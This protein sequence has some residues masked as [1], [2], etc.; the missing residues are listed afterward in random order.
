MGKKPKVSVVIPTHN[1]AQFLKAAIASVLNQTYQDFEIVVV[2]DASSDNTNEIVEGFGDKRVTYIRHEIN[3]G[4]AGSRNSGIANSSGDYLAFL[5]DDDEWL[6]EKLQMQVELMRN[7]SIKVGGVCTGSLSVE[8][9]SGKIS[10]I[11][12]PERKADSL[13]EILS[14]NFIATSSVLLRRECFEK[15]G[16][17]DE[18]IPYNSDYDMWIRIA[19]DYHFECI[20]EPLFIYHTHE[21]KLNNNLKLVLQGHERVLEKYNKFFAMDGR[22]LSHLHYTLGIL[23]SLD[24]NAGKS[25]KAFVKAIKSNPLAIKNYLALAVSFVNLGVLGKLIK[26]KEKIAASLRRRSLDQELDRLATNSALTTV[27]S[28]CRSGLPYTFQ[29]DL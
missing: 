3:K 12:I 13:Q 22:N 5:D 19:Q 29:K 16:L 26:I 9:R 8:K 7:S 4:D 28:I 2:D 24:R 23:Y 11:K 21:K 14:D 1:R 6:P 10:G 17:F 15:V 27:R 18:T 25:R 20:K